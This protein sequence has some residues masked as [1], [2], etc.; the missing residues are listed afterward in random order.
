MNSSSQNQNDPAP[1]SRNPDKTFVESGD[2]NVS[3]NNTSLNQTPLSLTAG[4]KIDITKISRTNPYQE[5]GTPAA[6]DGLPPVDQNMVLGSGTVVSILGTGGMAR[7]YKIWND[8]LEM[9]RAVKI[10]LP[11]QHGDL[12]HRFETESKIT[13]KL[14]HPNIVEIY[15]VGEWK[16]LPYL[17]M[18]YIDGESLEA[19]IGRYG[20]LPEAVCCAIGI[21][22]SRALAYAHSQSFLLYGKNYHGVIH[23]DLKP[24]NIMVSAKGGV[25]L[26]DF[27]I[28]RPTETSLHTVDGNIVGTMQYLSPEQLDG[29]A[30]DGRT[31]IYTLGAILYE[32]IT[33]TKTFP[34][35]TI[36]NLMKKKALNEYRRFNE[37]DFT[38]MPALG[39]IA[40][41]CLQ[42]NPSD[43]Y[44]VAADLEK[45]LT[46]LYGSLTNE[47]PEQT[48]QRFCS[49][50]SSIA[51][52]HAPFIKKLIKPVVYIPVAVLALLALLTIVLFATGPKAT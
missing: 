18:E 46:E 26:M 24:A 40:Q 47:T 11:N 5:K 44:Q 52:Y 30:I 19:V 7:V 27:G 43:R 23:R 21:F 51:V 34:Q 4:K 2:I 33:G 16:G 15:T 49:D 50:P 22:I 9:H 12:A 37:F 13:A 17:E 38:V 14:H 28:A 48:M 45:D 20:R 39:K 31:D 1:L 35:T 6:P 29:S 10:L 36:T 32:I 41:K 25:R 8:K 42:Q 3:A